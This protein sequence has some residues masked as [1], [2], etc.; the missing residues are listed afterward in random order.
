MNRRRSG[1]CNTCGVV[2]GA[3][4]SIACHI[5][6]VRR[7]QD[8]VEAARLRD[9]QM[10][11][12]DG[13]D[14]SDTQHSKLDPMCPSWADIISGKCKCKQCEQARF[15]HTVK[16][17]IVEEKQSARERKFIIDDLSSR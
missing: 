9:F 1:H 15:A 10:L 16:Q 11:K 12:S 7:E 2:I 4:R 13:V 3:K 6:C 8:P 14:Y 17:M 5:H